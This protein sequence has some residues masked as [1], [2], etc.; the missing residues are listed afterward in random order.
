MIRIIG[1]SYISCALSNYWSQSLA[2]LTYPVPYRII[3]HNH[4]PVLHV[5]CIIEL[6]ITII[7]PSYMSCAL[8]NYWSE[9]LARLT[10]PVARRLWCEWNCEFVIVFISGQVVDGPRDGA[11]P[12]LWDVVNLAVNSWNPGVQT[13]KVPHS[14]IIEVWSLY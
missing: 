10:C 9:S 1:P 4:W 12:A 6:S 7:G 3:D 5:L 14:S 8:S 2:R 11:S 13:A